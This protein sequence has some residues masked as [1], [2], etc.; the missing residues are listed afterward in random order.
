MSDKFQ[1]RTM[2]FA[3]ICQAA[4]LVQKVARDGSCD[5]AALRES[6]SSILVTN[7][8]QPLE[9]FNNTHLA[10]RDGYRALVEQLGLGAL[11]AAGDAGIELAGGLWFWRG[12]L[13]AATD[14]ADG[15]AVRS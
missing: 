1:D 15:H 9:V 10:I 14:R 11:L 7:P 12:K 5:E 3:G 13:C 2:A 4:Y 8:S 6:L